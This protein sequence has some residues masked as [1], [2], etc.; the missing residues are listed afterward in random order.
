MF[1]KINHR[2]FTYLWKLDRVCRQRFFLEFNAKGFNHLQRAKYQK[3]I[4]KGE[5]IEL[6]FE[7]KPDCKP[8]AKA[9]LQIDAVSAS[10]WLA[11]RKMTH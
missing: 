1:F 8:G 3:M 4:S 9:G 6:E 11:E 10:L 2:V 5:E 7:G